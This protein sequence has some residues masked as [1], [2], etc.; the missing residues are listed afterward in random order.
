[1]FI[2]IG[3]TP[4]DYAWGSLTGLSEALGTTPSGSPEAELWL[5]AHPGSPARILDPASVGAGTLAEWIAREPDAAL[6]GVAGSVDPVSGAPRLPFLLKVLAAGGPLSLQAHPSAETARR[7]FVDEEE[8]GIARD[9]ADRNYKDPFHK[10]ELMYALSESFDALCGFR[11]PEAA[12]TLF[13]ELAARSSGEAAEAITR[14][15]ATLDGDPAAVLRRAVSW[16]LADGDRAEVSALVAAVVAACAGDDRLE[17]ITVGDLAGSYPGDPGIVLSL[18]LNRV[19]LARGE[20]LYLPAGNIHAYLAG[21]GVEL[22]AA[23]DNVLRGGLTPKHIDVP[24]LVSVLDFSP[25]PVPYLSA[26]EVAPGVR[27]Y[28]PDVP[29]FV[30]VVVQPE[31]DAAARVTLRG[32]AIVI[33]TEGSFSLAGA[34]GSARVERGE[35]MFVT[36]SEGALSVTGRGTLFVATV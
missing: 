25:L 8:A 24:E 3:N 36:P 23:S 32:P 11:E 9:A 15:A 30:L 35:S 33:A 10:P 4:R 19:R 6:A 12:R 26:E 14:F 1:M 7:R 16:L 22:M 29:D 20:V 2:P 28:R 17:T 31:S 21:T 34:E 27:V 5:G 13:S 18:L